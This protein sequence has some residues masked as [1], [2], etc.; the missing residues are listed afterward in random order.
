[1]D[2]VWR[3]RVQTYD[4]T[5]GLQAT[6]ALFAALQQRRL[7]DPESARRCRSVDDRLYVVRSEPTRLGSVITPQT[8]TQVRVT[9]Y[10]SRDSFMQVQVRPVK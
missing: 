3:N 2:G 1:V 4:S 5:F 6:D 10:N 9:S 8:G 7:A